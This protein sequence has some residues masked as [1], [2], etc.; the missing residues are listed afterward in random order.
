M[1]LIKAK[2][3]LGNRMLSTAS[4]VVYAQQTKRDYHIDWSDGIYAPKSENAYT[5][6]F[7]STQQT[8]MS[9]IIN[10][11]WK[12]MPEVW[13][14]QLELSPSEVISKY[15]A[16]HHS[17]PFISRKLS[18]PLS[19][20]I[21]QKTIEVFWAYTS[22]MGRISQVL[23]ETPRRKLQN[24]FLTVLNTHFK[25]T[26]K[27]TNRLDDFFSQYNSILGVHVRYT[28]LK[29]S[30]DKVV[31]SVK[32]A[33]SKNS[34]TY[35]FLSTDSQKV[36]NLF[37]NKFDNV[38]TAEKKFRTGNKQ[39]HIV[40]NYKE[41]YVDA[42]AAVFDLYALARCNALV[43]SSKSS[44][45]RVSA[46]VGNFEKKDLFDIDQL[47]LMGQLKNKMQEYF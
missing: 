16:K 42:E 26:E 43:F 25:P 30:L 22:K 6:L 17:D 12:V 29:V 5:N 7:E 9:T 10:R 11:E 28:D 18:A 31:N 3:G 8:D 32:K 23:N 39:L 38:I 35:L 33:Q 4:A 14:N 47:N 46:L 41:K 13:E 40:E 19:K 37:R 1:F 36:E 27:L 24:S 34:N 2:G 15:Y 21:P 20:E 45:S 44:F